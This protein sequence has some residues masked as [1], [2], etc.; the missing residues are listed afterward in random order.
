MPDE[1]NEVQEELVT[2]TKETWERFKE[3][4]ELL[5][6]G[7]KH[8]MEQ[9]EIKDL[10]KDLAIEDLKKQFEPKSMDLELNG[11]NFETLKET[12]GVKEEINTDDIDNVL[13]ENFGGH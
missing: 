11:I 3:E 7:V 2:L 10:E 8:Y 1:E 6:K 12:L 13:N 9:L 5:G 4:Y